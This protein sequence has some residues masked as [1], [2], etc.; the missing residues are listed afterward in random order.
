MNL[1]RIEKKR[2]R[3][4]PWRIIEKAVHERG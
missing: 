4:W 1:V 2:E 3:I